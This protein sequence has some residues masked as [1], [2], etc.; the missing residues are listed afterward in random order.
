MKNI[1]LG[2]R[3]VGMKKCR[4][5]GEPVDIY[6]QYHPIAKVKAGQEHCKNDF[7]NDTDCPFHPDGKRL[8]LKRKIYVIKYI[9]GG[10][11]YEYSCGCG[12]IRVFTL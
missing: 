10:I 9:D 1:K 12:R 6:Q 7:C 2:E 5:T 4:K 11:L 8:W 3:I